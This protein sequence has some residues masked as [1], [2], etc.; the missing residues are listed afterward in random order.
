[1]FLL[2]IVAAVEVELCPLLVLK[3]LSEELLR[4]AVELVLSVGQVLAL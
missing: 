4:M 1:V 3:M 2:I